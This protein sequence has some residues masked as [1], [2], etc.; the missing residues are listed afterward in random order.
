MTWFSDGSVQ[1]GRGDSRIVAAAAGVV[2][3]LHYDVAS[4]EGLPIT[5]RGYETVPYYCGA[6]HH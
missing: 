5:G 3:G 4:E 2:C 6:S 1:R